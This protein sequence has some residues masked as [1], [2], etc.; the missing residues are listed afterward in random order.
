[1]APISQREARRLMKLV[2]A[3]ER[4]IKNQRDRWSG[5]Y[6]GKE[7]GRVSWGQADS[8]PTAIRTARRLDHAVVAISSENSGEIRFVALPHPSESIEV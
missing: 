8:I 6:I 4:Q 3:L 1:M 2:A 7:I 5:D